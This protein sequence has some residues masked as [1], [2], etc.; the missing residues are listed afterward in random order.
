VARIGPWGGDGNVLHDITEKPHHL[1]RVTI[2]S[3][4][5]INSLEYIYNDHMGSSTLL[6]HGAAVEETA[7]R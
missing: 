7:E 3:G 2:F 1:Q 5:I 6:V 4:A